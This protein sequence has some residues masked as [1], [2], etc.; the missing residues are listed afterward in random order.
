MKLFLFLAAL[1]IT[2]DG[3]NASSIRETRKFLDI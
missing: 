3:L 1:V 2:I